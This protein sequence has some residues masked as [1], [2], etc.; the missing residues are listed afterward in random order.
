[1]SRNPVSMFRISSKGYYHKISLL[2]SLVTIFIITDILLSNISPASI[3]VDN[4]IHSNAGIILFI[5]FSLAS[6]VAQI[7]AL[8]YIKKNGEKLWLS[9]LHLKQTHTTVMIGQFVLISLIFT[10]IVQIVLEGHYNVILLAF[11]TTISYALSF[12]VMT[13]L[14]IRLFMWYLRKRDLVILIF[15]IGSF[16]AAFSAIATIGFSVFIFGI[17]PFHASIDTKTS[18]PILVP[19]STEW[20]LYYFNSLFSIISFIATWLGAA[21]LL[22]HYSKKFAHNTYWII[23]CAPLVYFL[24]QFTNILHF[25]DPFIKTDL[26]AIFIAYQ[27][28]FSLNSTIG[29]VLFAIVF[30]TASKKLEHIATLKNYLTIAGFG[31]F[32]FFASGSATVVQIP[33]PPYGIQMVSIVGISSY[34][35]F[36]GLYSSAVVISDD[37]KVRQTIRNSAMEQSKLLGSI[38]Y[39]EMEHAITHHVVSVVKNI[40][41][42]MVEESGVETNYADYDIKEQ[43]NQILEEIKKNTD[44]SH[45]SDKFPSE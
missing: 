24:S 38:S 5:L 2:V 31:F 17:S 22:R 32:L 12:I 7:A 40:S 35:I 27:L 36:F 16:T 10:I 43:I 39:A 19:G 30:W 41:D 18:F 1:M 13:I 42:K 28:V 8:N 4:F 45:S 11:V 14:A 3:P 25:Y 9:K 37:V 26:N 44:A 34:F 20:L 15:S 33:Y 23:V 21:L 6:A 29:G